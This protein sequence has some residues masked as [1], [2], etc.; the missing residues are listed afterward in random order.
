MLI[1]IDPSSSAIGWANFEDGK[2]EGSGVLRRRGHDDVGGWVTESIATIFRRPWAFEKRVCVV[3]IPGGRVHAGHSGGGS[4]LAVY[5]FAAGV[6][7]CVAAIW[8]PRVEAVTPERWCGGHSKEKRRRVA[9]KAA[10]WYDPAKDRGCD[11]SDAIA[12]GVW[13]LER[14][15]S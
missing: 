1:S 8:A 2:C 6:A 7:W 9:V 13:W 14:G 4:G 12:L 15:K 11:E 3:E 5:G 10:P